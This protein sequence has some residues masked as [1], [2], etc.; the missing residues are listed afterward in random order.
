MTD[1]IQHVKSMTKP[2][3]LE[4]TVKARQIMPAMKSAAKKKAAQAQ[5]QQQATG[6][7][8]ARTESPDL[9]AAL[10]DADQDLHQ[11]QSK[12]DMLDRFSDWA[13]DHPA[14]L[15]LLGVAVCGVGLLAALAGTALMGVAEGI[16]A[17]TFLILDIIGCGMMII[18]AH[19]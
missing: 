12:P 3:L 5:A 2:E 18:A 14:L 19:E 17:I 6:A 11:I 15:A 10:D 16:G 8:K 9:V 4:A 7:M 13:E 1:L